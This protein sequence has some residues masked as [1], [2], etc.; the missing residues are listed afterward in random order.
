MFFYCKIKRKDN[1]ECQLLAFFC[2]SKFLMI[3]LEKCWERCWSVFKIDVFLV[4]II[5]KAKINE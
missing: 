5:M 1:A 4:E 3:V 2:K